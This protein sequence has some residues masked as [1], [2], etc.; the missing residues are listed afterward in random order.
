MGAIREFELAGWRSAAA[1]Y[2][3]SFAA[4]TRPYVEALLDA[5]SLRR[6]MRLL[7][8][9]CGTGVAAAEAARR[10]AQ[11]SGLDFSPEMLAEATKFRR[12]VDFHQGDAEHLPFDDGAFDAAV[13]NFGVH[14]CERPQNAIAEA[15]RVLRPGG[16]FAFTLW[17]K[18]QDN[19]GWRLV[20]EAVAAHGRLDVA[21]PAG[22]DVR[23]SLED[24][25]A[26]TAGGGFGADSVSGTVVER[27]WALPAGADLVAVF[28]RGTVRVASLLRGQ[29]PE[30]LRA[31]RGHVMTGLQ[32]YARPNAIELPTRAFMICARKTPAP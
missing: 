7:D 2:E 8:I 24:F 18:P 10:G 13:S 15:H 19:P 22:S 27:T 31:I 9:A 17:V 21:M 11:A 29:S 14:H 28:E 6:G 5:V 30:A 26:L 25:V 20:H 32:N 16:R 1:A 23:N 4:A 12:G 3:A